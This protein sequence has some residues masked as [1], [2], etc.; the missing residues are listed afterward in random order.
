MN[1]LYR[2]LSSLAWC[3][4]AGSV[5]THLWTFTGNP[6]AI[7]MAL[8]IAIF[9]LWFALIMKLNRDIDKLYPG[10]RKLFARRQ[11]P[12]GRLL[13]PV[14]AQFKIM[15]VLLFLYVPFNFFFGIFVLNEGGTAQIIDGG[16]ALMNHGEFLRALTE[17]E[18][19][20]HLAYGSRIFSGHWMIF[21]FA[22]AIGLSLPDIQA[23]DNGLNLTPPSI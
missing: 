4:F 1:P 20:K 23:Q 16:Y 2:V 18:Y 9:P 5:L 10:P 14:P 3:G 15:G 6:P 19:F 7:T 8:H 13:A 22:A 12:W 17:Q 21:Y 11:M